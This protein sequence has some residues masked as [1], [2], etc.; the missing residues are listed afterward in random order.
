MKFLLYT[1]LFICIF[2]TT[3][4]KAQ[5]WKWATDA[6]GNGNTDQNYYMSTDSRGNVYWVGSVSGNAVFGTGT[7]TVTVNSVG[8]ICGVVAKYDS[9]GVFKWVRKITSNFSGYDIVCRAISIDRTDKIFISGSF[10][11]TAI[12]QG[13]PTL[14]GTGAYDMFVSRMDTSGNFVWCKKE[15]ITNFSTQ[16]TEMVADDSGNVYVAGFR[17][18]DG[19][20]WKYDSLGT[21]LWERNP[22]LN[23]T[24]G[25]GKL[26]YEGI[27]YTNGKILLCGSLYYISA[28]FPSLPPVGTSSHIYPLLVE[29]GSDGTALWSRAYESG[30][31]YL[32]DVKKNAYGDIVA[33][34]TLRGNLYLV[35]DT[36]TGPNTSNGDGIVI[37]FDS[38]GRDKWSFVYGY[39]AYNNLDRA[40][41]IVE[42]PNGRWYVAG[43]F[44]GTVNIGGT[45]ISSNAGGYDVFLVRLNP[46]GQTEWIKT[47][48]ASLY[49]YALSIARP[50]FGNKLYIGGYYSGP[51]TYGSTTI[52]DAGNGDAFMAQIADTTSYPILMHSVTA[53]LSCTNICSGAV[54]L[55]AY[56]NQNFV[57]S[58]V[59]EQNTTG[60]FDSL[61]AGVYSY[62]VTNG[63]SS[64][65]ISTVTVSNADTLHLSISSTF[66]CAQPYYSMQTNVS[67]GSAPYTYLWSNAAVTDNITTSD[68]LASTYSVR[69]VDDNGCEMID[70]LVVSGYQGKPNVALSS[71]FSCIAPHYTVHSAVS[72]GSGDYVYSWSN[73]ASIDSIAVSNTS[74]VNYVLEVSDSMGCVSADSV[75]LAGYSALT[76]GLNAVFNCTAPYYTLQ[77]NVAGGAHPYLYDW[78][79]GANTNIILSSDSVLTNYFLDVVDAN[80]CLLSDTVSVAGYVRK[81][82]SV[83]L[84]NDTL[85]VNGDTSSY[86]FV[87]LYNGNAISGTNNVMYHV[88]LQNGNYS[89]A[90]TDTACTWT[91]NSELYA[92]VSLHENI[93]AE[94]FSVYPNPADR[95]LYV[96]LACTKEDFEML[97]VIDYMGKRVLSQKQYSNTFTL[98]FDALTKGVYIVILNAGGKQVRKVI[99]KN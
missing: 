94:L 86:D 8:I 98:D 92:A 26:A 84:I 7:N 20:L 25:S 23:G 44:T 56:G 16:A 74:T 57:Y 93:N 11:T 87:W 36:L 75:L 66:T 52:N 29:Y 50:R 4:T 39:A 76:I 48:G 1:F 71:S 21:K 30:D 14:S 10:E 45:N 5:Q 99:V 22:T 80:G 33:V 69:V 32:F 27:S 82:L 77:S 64:P 38:L 97:S 13:G 43:Q 90:I 85:F 9:N 18:K 42:A 67:G 61:C 2:F 6:G 62:T 54:A 88:P 53:N 68:S 73:G 63:I 81:D 12:F 35:N 46:F 59:T 51:A 60:V 15:G 91:S 96:K 41:Q 95:L 83:V 55:N 89:I 3:S 24:V 47:N 19:L 40:M 49:D 17:M 72:G 79:N 31:A 37:G 78:S 58:I 65:L 34:G 28:T 70:S